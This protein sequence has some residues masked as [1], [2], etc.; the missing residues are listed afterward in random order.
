MS[1][2]KLAI[3]IAISLLVFII[4][5]VAV[6]AS[7][8]CAYNAHEA[9]R[10]RSYVVTKASVPKGTFLTSELIEARLG[11]LSESEDDSKLVASS[12]EALGKYTLAALTRDTELTSANLAP[13]PDLKPGTGR[14]AVPV[15]IKPEY[16][17]GL[18]PGL[19][20]YFMKPGSSVPA[21]KAKD[22]R[23]TALPILAIVPGKTFTTAVIALPLSEASLGKDLAGGDWVPVI[24]GKQTSQLK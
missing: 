20:V 24:V 15:A 9:K 19:E 18:E 21:V 17:V 5:V 6:V 8:K 12:Q 10:L 16:A 2:N 3:M 23:A 11:W 1:P 22:G 14:L 4:W 7:W 13:G